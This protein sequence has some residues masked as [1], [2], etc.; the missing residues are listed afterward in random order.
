MNNQ[1]AVK[2]SSLANTLNIGVAFLVMAI[3]GMII[4]PLP[5]LLLDFLLVLNISL[6]IIILVLTLF[7]HSVLEFLSFPTLLLVTTMFRLALNISSTRL[8]LSEGDAGQVIETFGNFVAGNNYI[9]GAVLFVII[10][11]VQLMV[12]TNGSGRVAEV[13]ARFTLDAMPGKQM[14]IDADLNSGLITEDV[15]KQRRS[16]LEKEANFYGAMDGASKFVKGD[17]MAGIIIT[18]I[19]LVGGIAIHSLQGDYSIGE[20]LTHF[21]VL[22]IGD[23]L[24]SQVPSLL[25]SVASGILVTRTSNGKGFG[26]TIGGDPRF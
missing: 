19:N 23:G 15:A 20:A 18:L 2:S 21:G 9:V 7:T 22:T 24:V 8:I 4:I 25:I 26:D 3:I 16:D 5:P 17:A 12:V 11:I 1:A 10:V 13:S 6:S 14:A